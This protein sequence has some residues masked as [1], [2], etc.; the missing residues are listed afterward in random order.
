M[1]MVFNFTIKGI[2]RK[3][4]EHTQTKCTKLQLFLML[5]DVK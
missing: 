5:K 4:Q 3:N 2:S 1:D